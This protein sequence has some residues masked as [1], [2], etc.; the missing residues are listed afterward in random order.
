M[1]GAHLSIKDTGTVIAVPMIA[2][3]Y[4][5]C[6]TMYYSDHSSLDYGIVISSQKQYED[7]IT[8]TMQMLGS[9][10][11]QCNRC[12]C[13]AGITTEA[14]HYREMI[15]LDLTNECYN[16][17][18]YCQE[19]S[20]Q[21]QCGKRSIIGMHILFYGN[22]TF[23]AI[24]IA[25]T[26]LFQQSLAIYPNIVPI[27]S[28]KQVYI[29]YIIHSR[30]STMTKG[31]TLQNPSLETDAN[32]SMKLTNSAFG[33]K[34]G[35]MS[36][37][38]LASHH[39]MINFLCGEV[40][41][42]EPIESNQESKNLSGTVVYSTSPIN[43]FTN[44]LRSD[45]DDIIYSQI[46]HQMPE[47][48]RWGRIFILDMIHNKLIPEEIKSHLIYEITVISYIP[49][50]TV[51]MK[52]DQV[53]NFAI[54]KSNFHYL[55]RGMYNQTQMM[56]LSHIEINSI[57]PLLVIFETYTTTVTSN[58]SVHYSVLAQPVEWY[59]NKQTVLL[60]HPIQHIIY[61][62]HISIFVP[63]NDSNLAD[64][65]ESDGGLCNQGLPISNYNV[66]R[67]NTSF[68][69]TMLSYKRFFIN[70]TNNQ[71]Q[72]LLYHSNPHV[73]I[74][75]TVYAYSE[76]LH[77]SYSNGYT[78]GMMM[79]MIIIII[80]IMCMIYDNQYI[81]AIQVMRTT[82]LEPLLLLLLPPHLAVT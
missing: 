64:I 30:H 81:Q 71:T 50:S 11:S 15:L 49:N 37:I 51:T 80:I 8:P 54:R 44:L 61:Q 36:K 79:M 75:V 7:R 56:N 32:I 24:V 65:L 76:T 57:S 68:N 43:V 45:K 72:L 14:I 4:N 38:Y 25:I 31:I 59:A 42:I 58:N 34:N 27:A 82:V 46:A 69:Y 21:K 2:Q 55:W 22:P 16:Q 12:A 10:G 41:W 23:T 13:P 52:F 53:I 73:Q 60:A 1:L 3:R 6:D 19:F 39:S 20:L 33:L 66:L 5:Y 9:H 28:K 35:N 70:S 62:Y 26:S 78:L 40:L 77:Y 63:T 17:S 18:G 74:G 48:E 67:N 47:K 29:Y